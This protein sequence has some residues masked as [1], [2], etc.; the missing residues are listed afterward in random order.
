MS[1]IL[2]WAYTT[3]N[4]VDGTETLLSSGKVTFENNGP[5]LSSFSPEKADLNAASATGRW[6]D[7]SNQKDLLFAFTQQKKS[8]GTSVS[9]NFEHALTQIDIQ[10]KQDKGPNPQDHRVVKIR[11]AWI[12]NVNTQGDLSA[13]FSWDG[14]TA[15]QNP[16]WNNLSVNGCYGSYYSAETTLD[17]DQK[18]LLGNSGSLM[19]IPQSVNEPQSVTEDTYILL[20]CRIELKHA[21]ASHDGNADDIFVDGAN[22]QHYHQLFPVADEYNAKQYGFACVKLN[23]MSWVMG[24][25]YRYVLDICGANSGAGIYPPGSANDTYDALVPESERSQTEPNIIIVHRKV[26]DDG[27]PVLDDPIKFTVTVESWPD[28]WTAGNTETNK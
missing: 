1:T 14:K 18:G 7:G 21:G 5:K 15:T 11:G 3:D 20:L 26:K 13:S 8:E 10:A 6:D 23:S 4:T 24:M 27:D 9:L 16:N 19:I 17:S 25:K 2:F 12:Y 22:N 28:N